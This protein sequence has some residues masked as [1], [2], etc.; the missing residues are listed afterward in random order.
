MYRIQSESQIGDNLLLLQGLHEGFL[1]P[2]KNMLEYR[3]GQ[4]SI[5]FLWGMVVWAINRDLMFRYCTP[6][7]SR[8]RTKS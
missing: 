6:P 8:L 5:I 1:A 4:I 3:K 2:V 7:H